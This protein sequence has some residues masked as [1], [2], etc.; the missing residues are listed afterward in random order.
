MLRKSRKAETGLKTNPSRIIGIAVN[1]STKIKSTTQHRENLLV[2]HVAGETFPEGMAG[3]GL[4]SLLK[5][6]YCMKRVRI[7]EDFVTQKHT[8]H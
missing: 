5:H 6:H 3:N 2:K 8:H 7:R 1:F 4:N